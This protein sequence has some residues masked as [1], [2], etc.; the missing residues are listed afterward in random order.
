MTNDEIWQIIEV[1]ES[2]VDEETP[3][4]EIECLITICPKNANYEESETFS[5][6]LKEHKFWEKKVGEYF[7]MSK[8][9]H[10]GFDEDTNPILDLDALRKSLTKSF[11]FR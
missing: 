8:K 4:K 3:N 6:P 1:S 2:I 5:M 11:V 10:K 7:T 9:I